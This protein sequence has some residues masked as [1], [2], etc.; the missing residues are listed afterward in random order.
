MMWQV[1]IILFLYFGKFLI[2]KLCINL[3]NFEGNSS[4]STENVC[5][6]WISYKTE[7]CI[8]IFA[9]RDFQTYDD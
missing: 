9:D 4:S 2:E 7:K 3:F 1:I 6:N 5:G 8:R